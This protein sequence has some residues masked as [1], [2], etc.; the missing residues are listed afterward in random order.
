ME[1]SRLEGERYAG[2]CLSCCTIGAGESNL[3]G[4]EVDCRFCD[5]FVERD[6]TSELQ[7][8]VLSRPEVEIE[9]EI[10]LTKFKME[11]RLNSTPKIRYDSAVPL[12]GSVALDIAE[13]RFIEIEASDGTGRYMKA[14]HEAF[15]MC[16]DTNTRKSPGAALRSIGNG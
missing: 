15:V 2:H 10:T 1:P 3:P 8:V 7:C 11:Y 4:T 14:R 5:W 6:V 12:D 16:C 13:V 9:V